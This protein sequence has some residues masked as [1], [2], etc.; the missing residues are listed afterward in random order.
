MKD[1]NIRKVQ[2]KDSKIIWQIRNNP[3]ARKNSTSLAKIPYQIHQIWFKDFLNNERNHIFVLE[4][5]T[6]NKQQIVGYCRYEQ[7]QNVFDISIAI[8]QKY[9][10]R[11]FGQFM[12]KETL[13]FISK[14]HLPI[15]AKVKKS[16][17]QSMH[18]F[19]KNGFII[20]HKDSNSCYFLLK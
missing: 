1:L 11:G 5:N 7:K 18:I 17:Y 6:S 15:L 16:N 14:F 8:D 9:I 19:Q 10:N 4:Q 12:L 13:K 20:S 3:N 2:D